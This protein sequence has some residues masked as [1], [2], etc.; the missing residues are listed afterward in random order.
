[1]SSLTRTELIDE[2]RILAGRMGQQIVLTKQ[3]DFILKDIT[4]R[5][6]VLKN[7]DHPFTTVDEQAW[8]A[9]P[10][11]YRPWEGQQCFYG[12]DELCWLEPE[13]YFRNVRMFTDTPSTPQEFTVSID[14]N[15]LY[16]WDKPDAATIGHLYYAAIHPK[17]NKSLAF[18]S[19]G[20][21]EIVRGNTVTGATGAATMVVGFVRVTSGSWAGGDAAGTILGVVTGT[22]QA[23][24]LNI[25]ATL[26]VATISGDATT[27]D[28]FVHFI[29][30]DFDDT[31]IEGLVWRCLLK[32]SG[33]DPTIKAEAR[34][35]M[36][37]YLSVLSDTAQVKSKQYVSTKYRDF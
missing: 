7:I 28:N 16:F 9:L 1:M 18:T 15:R 5:Y 31:I 6:P 20:T 26:N 27:A 14:E 33:M 34:D 35:Q 10:S 11:D 22:F 21:T 8:I 36:Q 4:R 19:G 2:A 32:L 13:D 12:D 37:S 23:E 17:A 25:G 3:F 30:E 29:G 24:N